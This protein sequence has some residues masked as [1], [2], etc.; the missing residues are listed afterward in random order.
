MTSLRLPRA[1]LVQTFETELLESTLT[2]V[3]VQQTIP[4]EDDFDED[5]SG[6]Y[7]IFV[8]RPVK[9]RSYQSASA[10]FSH[11]RYEVV[12]SLRVWFVGMRDAAENETIINILEDLGEQV[13]YQDF[14]AV[15]YEAEDEYSNAAEIFTYTYEFL[16]YEQAERTT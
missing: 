16:G 14:Y 13:E 5:T 7:G 4:D 2:G 9:K 10:N 12:Y 1:L 15:Q 11:A 8:G 3:P 6:Q